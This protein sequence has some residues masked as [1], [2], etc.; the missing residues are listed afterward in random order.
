MAADPRLP[1]APGAPDDRVLDARARVAGEDGPGRRVGE[2][3]QVGGVEGVDAPVLAGG[4]RGADVQAPPVA[5]GADDGRALQRRGAEALLAEQA[6][7]TSRSPSS[8][9]ATTT[10]PPRPAAVRVR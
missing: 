4:R 7:G 1:S 10:A 6:T 3:G 5:S 2:P 8:E 9:R